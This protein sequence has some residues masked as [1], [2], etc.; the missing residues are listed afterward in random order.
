MAETLPVSFTG[1]DVPPSLDFVLSLVIPVY[2]E[3]ETLP[4]ILRAAM[5]IAP[6]SP[7]NLLLS[8]IFDRWDA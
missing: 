1:F 8:M 6:E 7:K 4:R 3:L 5:L 2:N